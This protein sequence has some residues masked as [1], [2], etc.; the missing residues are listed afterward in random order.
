[1]K[2][3]LTIAITLLINSKISASYLRNQQLQQKMLFSMEI[4]E[5]I[6][7]AITLLINNQIC[8]SNI[9]NQQ[10]QQQ[11]K[12]RLVELSLVESRRVELS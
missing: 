4:R 10:H 7:K 11:D 5:L 8:A 12:T 2:R 6:N 1:M 3:W 9:G